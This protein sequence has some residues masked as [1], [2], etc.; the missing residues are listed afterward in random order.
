MIEKKKDKYPFSTLMRDITD[1]YNHLTPK[2]E[3]P[4]KYQ[5]HQLCSTAM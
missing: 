3:V 2:R 1:I 5:S 4:K